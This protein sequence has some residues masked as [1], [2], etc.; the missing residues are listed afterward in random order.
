MPLEEDEQEEVPTKSPLK[1]KNQTPTPSP[2]AQRAAFEQT[3]TAVHARSEERKKE[4]YEL[5]KSFI[6]MMKDKTL[7]DNK[8]PIAQNIERDVIK[9]LIEVGTALNNDEDQDE[10]AGSIG[11]VTLLMRALLAQRNRINELEFKLD[12]FEK[13]I[14]TASRQAEERTKDK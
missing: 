5:S 6:G 4:I 9:Q 3:A 1:V 7:A 13:T 14:G 8:G 12:K 10:G 11:L 2:A